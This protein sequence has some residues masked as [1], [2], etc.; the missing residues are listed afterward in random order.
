MLPLLGHVGTWKR[1]L[2]IRKVELNA[3]IVNLKSSNAKIA[4]LLTVLNASY[5]QAIVDLKDTNVRETDWYEATG[6]DSAFSATY[7][8]PRMATSDDAS[9]HERILQLTPS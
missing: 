8:S 4:R 1:K 2:G 7:R 6:A 9:D 5:V 3:E